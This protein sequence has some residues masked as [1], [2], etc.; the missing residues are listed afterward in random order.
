MNKDIRNDSTSRAAR[1]ETLRITALIEQAPNPMI[2]VDNLGRIRLLNQQAQTLFGYSTADLANQP[3][4]LL[5]P[6]DL[7]AGHVQLRNQYL[8]SPAARPMRAALTLR[9]IRKDHTEFLA[10]I[11]LRPLQTADG[12]LIA[13]AIAPGPETA[14]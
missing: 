5:I 9:C 14:E 8:K 13:A 4:E 12:M 2:V 1:A 10:Q 11:S 3:I 6:S 7:R